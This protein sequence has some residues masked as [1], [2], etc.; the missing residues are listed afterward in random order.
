MATIRKMRDKWQ[1]IVKR[2]GYPL[3]SKS[4]PIRAD[5]R[6]WAREAESAL[7]NGIVVTGKSITTVPINAVTA[8]TDE[9]KAIDACE[10]STVADL[11][12]RYRDTVAIHH[13]GYGSENARIK[14]F[15]HITGSLMSVM[16]NRRMTSGDI[17]K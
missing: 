6:K 13:R 10:C 7:D 9:P 17:S 12:K 8:P 15:L 16:M 11:L 3:Q 5:A 1:A 2:S 4:F 14:V